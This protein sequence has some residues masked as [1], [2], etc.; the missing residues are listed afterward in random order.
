M[1]EVLP[2]GWETKQVR[3][4]TLEHKQGFYSKDAYN[5]A[6]TYLIRITDLSNPTIDYS[7]MPKLVIS[8]KEF[9]QFRVEIGDFLFARSGAIGRYGIVARDIPAV[10]ASY[11]I[12]FRFDEQ[13]VL[14]QYFGYLYESDI[15][16][17][18]LGAI[19]QGSSNININADN[20]KSLSI[21]APPLPEQ[22]KIAKTLASVD[23][24]IEKT[25]AQIDKLKDLKTAMMQALLTKGIGHTEFKDSAVGRI[26]VGWEVV[27]L[28]ELIEVIESGW[29]PQCETFPATASD[30]GV[31]KTT[32]VTWDGFNHEANKKLPDNLKPRP[33]TQVNAKDILITRAG[34]ADRVGVVAYVERVREK[35]MLSDKIIRLI[36]KQNC[37]PKFLSL[38]LSSDTTKTY[39]ASRVSGLAQSQTNI[40][41][42]ILKICPCVLPS[43]NEQQKIANTMSSL[44]K[45]LKRLMD[46][47]TQQKSLKKALMQDLLTGKV[48]VNIDKE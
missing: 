16:Q 25:Q 32:A 34:P 36:V 15:C 14:T 10:F 43:M 20:I 6:G 37:N 42:D 29:S 35:I 17:T 7:D 33:A 23:K 45:R 28:V 39:I 11:L 48:R 19:T 24:V 3:E 13:L 4:F 9:N 26:P 8:K 2:D 46:K 1:S 41:Q 40:S 38:W 18:Q 27:P 12:R 30:W 44:E 47:S 22:Q 5:T 21:I 31:L